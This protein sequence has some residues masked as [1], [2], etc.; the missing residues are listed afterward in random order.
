MN[1]TS[2]V[3]RALRGA[4]WFAGAPVRA[5]LIALIRLYRATLAGLLGGQCRFHPTCSHYAEEAIKARGAV[6]G[7]ALSAWRVLRCT[8]FSRAGID[9]PPASR[10]AGPPPVGEYDDV[11]LPVPGG[12]V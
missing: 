3:V 7:S 4:I 6:A 11:I 5:V 12:R 1:L 10:R 2:R 9:P 8:P